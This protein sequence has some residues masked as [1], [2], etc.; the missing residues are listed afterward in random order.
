MAMRSTV[1][2]FL[3]DTD[4]REG[5]DMLWGVTVTSFAATGENTRALSYG[6]DGNLLPRSLGHSA[7][8]LFKAMP[9]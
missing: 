9:K 2:R 8:D 7:Y 5:F 1:S 6:S 4:A 3:M